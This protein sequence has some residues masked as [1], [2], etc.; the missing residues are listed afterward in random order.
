MHG[1]TGR[2]YLKAMAIFWSVFGLITTFYP[3]L[4]ELFMS[5]RGKDATTAFSD[6][7]WLHGGLDIL[8]VAVL[9]FVLSTFRPTEIIL[10]GAAV[11]AL[12]PT[13]A[14]IYTLVATP[15]W[16][17]LFLIPG[18]GCFAFAV[19]GFVLA[20]RYTGATEAA[21]APAA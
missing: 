11:V 16:T 13:A 21:P 4:M 17:P 18:V 14:I 10:K 7:V 2:I 9:L 6:Q 8:S 19:I 15:F 5:D 20:R 1:D 3:K 12:M